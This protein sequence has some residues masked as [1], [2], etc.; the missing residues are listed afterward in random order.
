MPLFRI[1]AVY[2]RGGT[3]KGVFF[4]EEDLPQDPVLRKRL[5]VRAVGSPDGYGKQIDG[6]GTGISSTSKVVVLSRSN[7]PGC[8]I[9]YWF[10]H[11][12]VAN[13]TLDA[14]GN[15]GNLSAAVG[16]AAMLLG[17]LPAESPATTVRIWQVNVSQ[18]IE[19]VVPVEDGLPAVLGNF[20]LDGVS[21]A[22]API[23]LAF[24]DPAGDSALFPT[25]R[26]MDRL[27]V[28]GQG[29]I[30]ATLMDC[31]NP[32]VFVRAAGLG[33]TGTELP[34]DI[35][36]NAA[37]LAR[38]EAIR[39]QAAVTMGLAATPEQASR[40]RPATPKLSFVSTPQDYLASDGTPIAA[41]DQHLTARILSFG[42][43]HHAFTGTGSIALAVAA[44]IP[45]TLPQ[46]LC[47][48][49]PTEMVRFGH[50][51]GI[52]DVAVTLEEGAQGWRAVSVDMVR[53]ARCLMQGEVWIPLD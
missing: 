23:Q 4:R 11:I 9:D 26:L 51:A 49:T 36:G 46:Q 18:R 50:V 31:G 14:S 27:I 52:N 1:P 15:C 29:E 35:N 19:A 12:D 47:S 45:G 7:Q 8:D 20:R 3:S 2:M 10:G 5:L 32:A 34:A 44:R 13:G 53:T 37:L 30:D 43:L 22:G 16:P 42:Q 17:L 48:P 24:L 6:L 38:C 33:L 40:E 21:F 41:A 28:P 39:A 25:G